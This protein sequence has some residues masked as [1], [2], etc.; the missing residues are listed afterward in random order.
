MPVRH[1]VRVYS[2]I[3]EL[4]TVLDDWRSLVIE[5]RLN[6][7]STHT[8]TIDGKSDNIQYFVTDALVE[9]QRSDKA[10]GLDWYTEYIGFHRTP[11]FRLSN[12]GTWTFTSYGRSLEDLLN[13]RALLYKTPY[14][15]TQPADNVMKLF[16]YDNL[17]A[18][19]T[20]PPRLFDGV[21]LGFA[22]DAL[23]GSAPEWTGQRAYRN[24]LETLQ[25]IS[26]AA[27]VDFNVKINI[28]GPGGFVFSTYYPQLGVD[29]TVTTGAVPHIFSPEFGNVKVPVYTISRTEEANAI[30]V[31]GQGE[32]ALREVI[33]VKNDGAIDDSPYNRIEM[34]RDARNEYT[35]LG[36][37]SVGQAELIK[38]Q[39]QESFK[40]DVLQTP[41]S[42][43]GRDYK[44]G[45]LVTARLGQ[46]VIDKKI[47]GV[48]LVVG[49]SAGTEDLSF[50]FGDLEPVYNFNGAI[51]Q[52][53]HT[54]VRRLRAIE[55]SSEA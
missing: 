5:K 34:T 25:D 39:A 38:N 8:L 20:S 24:L 13:R 26:A 46:A 11:D 19:A 43:Y 21:L 28:P 17:S 31:M 6:G 54:I 50:N 29:R 49:G 27:G 37:Q 12:N 47:T 2:P 52:A 55:N 16:V 1:Q 22:V 51:T 3:G 18:G 53:L 10:V 35:T 33:E 40:F 15:Y 4:R 32:E 42:I 44:L 7:F 14:G 36:L 30:I 23:T 9:V 48:R 45:D 41:A